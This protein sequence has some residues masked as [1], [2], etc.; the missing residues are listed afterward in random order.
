MYNDFVGNGETM[1]DVDVIYVDGVYHLFHLVLPNHDFVAHSISTDGVSWTRVNNAIFIGEPGSWDDSMLWTMHVSRDPYE[2]RWRMFYTGLSRGD[3]Q[4][5]QRI[6]MATS[7][8]LMHW[9]KAPSHWPM[10]ANLKQQ[11]DLEQ[12]PN[13]GAETS[14]LAPTKIGLARTSNLFQSTSPL[15]LEALAQ[16]YEAS[17]DVGRNWV[18]WRDP[19]FFQH[20]ERKLIVCSARINSGPVVRRGC[21]G[22]IEET[23]QGQF[24]V[25]PTIFH[26]GLYDD[27][28]VPNLIEIDGTYFL[29][30][31][32][33]E[34][35]KIRYWHATDLDGPWHSYHDN[36]LLP[37]G[38]YAGRICPDDR[39]FLIWNVFSSDESRK[40]HNVMPPP[41]RLKRC[42]EGLL[43]AVSFEGIQ[44][45]VKESF[46]VSSIETLRSCG[47]AMHPRADTK[48]EWDGD[49]LFLKN[50][51][52]FQPFVFRDTFASFRLQA[53]LELVGRG[54]CGLLL[55]FD[56]ETH[57]GYYLSLDIRK[58]IAQCRAWGADH[59][60]TGE[61]VMQFNALQSAYWSARRDG[62]VDIE[63]IAFGSYLE[64]SIDGQVL[65]SLVDRTYRA[66]AV[67]F[68][69]ETAQVKLSQMQLESLR[70]PSQA[71][72]HLTVG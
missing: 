53:Q 35:A 23:E 51:A 13:H 52:G 57:D 17:L 36:V 32:I 72:D 12:P 42:S 56:R 49:Q 41:K 30:G 44:K 16:F 47:A 63:M 37:R 54:K 68:Y 69:L 28:E 60:A 66:G 24:E 9:T 48:I 39:G 22:L 38:N 62:K 40:L 11:L 65:L 31:S 4:L 43:R 1:G 20:G 27:I 25:R 55:R 29:I 10:P 67:G 21:V 59:A 6:G 2:K 70:G 18:S 8:D 46:P 50:D 7:V 61:N 34:D 15:P 64:L 5:V 19:Y 26:P 58:G 33:R 3:H 45:R 14:Q 71:D